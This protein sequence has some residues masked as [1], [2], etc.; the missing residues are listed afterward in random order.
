MKNSVG[1]VRPS[2]MMRRSLKNLLKI[3]LKTV[4]AYL[5]KE[6]LRKLWGHF[7]ITLA[8]GF[9]FDWCCAA[10]AGGDGGVGPKP[11]E[12]QVVL[13]LEGAR[14]LGERLDAGGLPYP[15]NARPP[16]LNPKVV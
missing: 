8:S 4:R 12:D 6:E 10:S 13:L 11:V 16:R 3:N 1:W 2:V 7:S 9:L 14:D 5:L 15:I